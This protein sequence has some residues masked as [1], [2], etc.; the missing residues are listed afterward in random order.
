MSTFQCVSETESL[1][2]AFAIST[3]TTCVDTNIDNICNYS[4]KI[5]NENDFYPGFRDHMITKTKASEAHVYNT[6]L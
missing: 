6:F 4:T 3:E 2:I 1:L 5:T